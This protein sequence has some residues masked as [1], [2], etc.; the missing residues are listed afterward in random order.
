MKILCFTQGAHTPAVEPLAVQ[1]VPRALRTHRPF[2]SGDVHLIWTNRIRL[3]VL[4]R[5]FRQTDRFTDV[6]SFRYDE[7]PAV[8]SK[9]LPF[10]DLYIATDQAQ[11]NAVRFGVTLDE[12]I[13]RLATHGALHLLGYT[14]YT[15]ENRDRMW[16]IQEPLV[17]KI[18][19]ST[20]KPASKN[21]ENVSLLVPKSLTKRQ[22]F[23][24]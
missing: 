12:E 22:R 15:P 16:A 21:V 24:N 19:K 10:G 13:V 20:E 2:P 8:P 14:D 7:T 3:R 9:S 23:W 1:A 4:N 17:R 6:I 11:K 5:R 18:L